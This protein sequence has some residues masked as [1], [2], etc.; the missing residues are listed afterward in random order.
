VVYGIFH[1][2]R[3]SPGLRLSPVKEAFDAG[4]EPLRGIKI[5]TESMI[6]LDVDAVDSSRTP[7]FGRNEGLRGTFFLSTNLNRGM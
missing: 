5:P 3:R 7:A 6:G 4:G 1:D 2:L